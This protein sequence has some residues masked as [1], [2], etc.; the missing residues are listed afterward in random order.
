MLPLAFESPCGVALAFRCGGTCG[1]DR[2][3]GRTE[4]VRGDVCDGPGLASSVCGMPCGPTQVSGDEPIPHAYLWQLGEAPV[5]E[6]QGAGA[7][8]GGQRHPVYWAVMD[9][10]DWIAVSAGVPARRES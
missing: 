8:F 9:A 2:V 1:L 5:P 7:D 10:P 4:F 6:W 3:G